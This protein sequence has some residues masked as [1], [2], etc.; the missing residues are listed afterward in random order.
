MIEDLPDDRRPLDPGDHLHRAAAARTQEGID[1][2]HLPDEAGPGAADLTGRPIVR[3]GDWVRRLG[4][5]EEPVPLAVAPHPIGVPAIEEHGLLVR[6]RDVGTHL[7]EEVPYVEPGTPIYVEDLEAWE[8]QAGIKVS[9]GDALFVR[10][11]VWPYRKKFG[12]WVRGRAGKDAGLDPTVIPWLKKRDIAILG[13]DHPQG[14]NPTEV[15]NAVHDFSL[16]RL[17]VHL[18]DNCDLEALADAAAARKRWEFM[19]TVAPL[20]VRGSTGSPVNPIA[21]F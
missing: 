19:L 15:P 17:G 7:G 11:G 2:V 18:L 21:T 12:P 4:F 14:V 20:P 6:I 16:V 1:L 9:S 10:T 5:R 13:S 8:K 3:A